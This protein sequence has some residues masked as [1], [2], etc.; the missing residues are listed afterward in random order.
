V[1]RDLGERAVAR[2][3]RQWPEFVVLLVLIA[4]VLVVYRYSTSPVRR[5]TP[6]RVAQDHAAH[7]LRATPSRES[8]PPASRRPPEDEQRDP[9]RDPD[10]RV[11]ADRARRYR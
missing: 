4:G 9:C 11:D 10:R 3:K 1:G 8:R 5:R 6:I 2:A 7:P